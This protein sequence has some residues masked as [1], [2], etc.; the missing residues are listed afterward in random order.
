MLRHHEWCTE[1][2][3]DLQEGAWTVAVMLTPRH[4]SVR[5]WDTTV[6]AIK[7][8]LDLDPNE[9]AQM[10]RFWARRDEAHPAGTTE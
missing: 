10:R 9:L 2:D 7:G 4:A 1:V 5:P 6:L 3:L 8:P